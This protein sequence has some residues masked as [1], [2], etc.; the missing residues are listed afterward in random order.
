[1]KNF[2]FWIIIFSFYGFSGNR[3]DKQKRDVFGI[4]IEID[5]SQVNRLQQSEVFI[6]LKSRYRL[7]EKKYF[8]TAQILV[9]DSPLKMGRSELLDACVEITKLNSVTLCE[10][11]LRLKPEGLKETI[12]CEKKLPLPSVNLASISRTLEKQCLF[13]P[14]IEGEEWDIFWA[15]HMVGADLL[16]KELEKSGV[17]EDDNVA[18]VVGVWDSGGHGELVSNIVAGPHQSAII[19]INGPSPFQDFDVTSMDNY[20]E[21]HRVLYL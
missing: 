3:E 4:L 1:M 21:Y 11:N 5:N 16:R 15:Q 20:L 12:E 8:S 9:L 6:K 2:Y 7:K 13:P 10:L 19:P 17:T 14:L 18:S